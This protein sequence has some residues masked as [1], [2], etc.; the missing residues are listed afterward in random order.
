MQ[1]PS[2]ILPRVPQNHSRNAREQRSQNRSRNAK[3]QQIH[4]TSITI[5]QQIHLPQNRSRNAREQRSLDNKSTLPRRTSLSDTSKNIKLERYNSYIRKVNS[6]K[7]LNA[8]SKLLFRATLLIALVLILFY[9]RNYPPV[10]DHPAS[11]HHQQLQF[12]IFRLRRWWIKVGETNQTLRHSPPLPAA[13]TTSPSSSPAPT[14]AAA[15]EF[16]AL[17]IST[18]TMIHG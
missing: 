10:V 9:T 15:M 2:E 1:P 6:T 16:S 12:S 7:L 17:T 18:P 3:A 11:P 8:S 13:P 4:L 5:E 14:H